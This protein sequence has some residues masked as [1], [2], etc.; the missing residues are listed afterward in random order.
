[1][2]WKISRVLGFVILSMV[3]TSFIACS[4]SVQKHLE[5]L[6]YYT[7]IGNKVTAVN[8]FY[9]E[10]KIPDAYRNRTVSS[11][12]LN[13][14]VYGE[15]GR[16]EDIRLVDPS[17]NFAVIKEWDF[18]SFFTTIPLE[19]LRG[20]QVLKLQPKVTEKGVYRIHRFVGI[21]GDD[22]LFY[23]IK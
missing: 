8:F 18:N 10:D 19:N 21:N 7:L 4:D 16:V 22:Y 13:F 20:Q 3:V 17:K 11:K 15:P 6:G 9:E 2:R 23:E 14:I 5:Q 12:D 1:M